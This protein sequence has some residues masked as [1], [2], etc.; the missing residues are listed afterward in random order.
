MDA[1]VLSWT[2]SPRLA[3][4]SGMS[5]VT[6]GGRGWGVLA[7]AFEEK[8]A[9]VESLTEQLN[10]AK[11]RAAELSPSLDSARR[12]AAA[13]ESDAASAKVSEGELMSA[14]AAL[15]ASNAKLGKQNK[16]LEGMVR[17]QERIQRQVAEKTK[18]LERNIGEFTEEISRLEQKLE[19]KQQVGGEVQRACT[20][21]RVGWELSGIGWEGMARQDGAD[22]GWA[23]CP[24][25]AFLYNRIRPGMH[26]ASTRPLPL[27]HSHAHP[28]STN[29]LYP[30]PP[31]VSMQ[32]LAE[33]QSRVAS[34]EESCSSAQAAAASA[35]EA[36]D[37]SR[38][39]VVERAREAEAIER[40][41]SVLLVELE[42]KAEVEAAY[43]AKR[44]ALA[45]AEA[46]V[47]GWAGPEEGRGG[48]KYA[49]KALALA[50]AAA[51]TLGCG[52]GVVGG[53]GGPGKADGQV[54]CS[55]SHSPFSFFPPPRW[56]LHAPCCLA[57]PSPLRPSSNLL[58]A[59]PSNRSS[60][61]H[62]VSEATS[63]AASER[64]SVADAA[65]RSS[66]EAERLTAEL[67]ATLTSGAAEVDATARELASVRE[68]LM[69][70]QSE[71]DR[72]LQQMAATEAALEAAQAEVRVRQPWA[73]FV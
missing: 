37:A 68:E 35:Q 73:A 70:L 41:L 7:E 14:Q 53:G 60:Q 29:S 20:R 9:L 61:V 66:A 5:Q 49:D 27:H 62:E 28:P 55:A 21:A 63:Q 64:D 3:L 72:E 1:N 50:E 17:V 52:S 8:E 39:R 67:Q 19:G 45:E 38:N 48:G 44:E 11:R 18:E 2:L 69:G 51:H 24:Y 12:A 71:R 40:Q 26:T 54:R 25:V 4:G 16:E 23:S 58:A 32:A 59:P 22:I 36:H 46:Q 42:R 10:A 33:A 34:A 6:L 47:W 56:G 13:A 57:R 31:S 43:T 30:H 15:T 65:A